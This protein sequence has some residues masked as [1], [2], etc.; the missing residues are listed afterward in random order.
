MQLVESLVKARIAD[1]FSTLLRIQQ[2]KVLRVAHFWKRQ[3]PIKLT[4]CQATHFST[5]K[6]INTPA[7]NNKQI[8]I[9]AIF[10]LVDPVKKDG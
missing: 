2:G 4:F 6:P 9:A 8:V 7:K 3:F 5:K 10:D 1:D